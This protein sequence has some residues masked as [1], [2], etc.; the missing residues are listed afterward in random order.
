MRKFTLLEQKEFLFNSQ[1]VAI[2]TGDEFAK[3]EGITLTQQVTEY[4]TAVGGKALSP[5]YGEVILDKKGVDDDFAHG[6][7]RIK[8][9]A[10]AAV[11]QIIE[12]GTIILPMSQHKNDS[13]IESAMIGAPIEI[14]SKEYIGVVVIRRNK[15]G[16]T[17]LYIHEVTI[18]Q[19]LLEGSSNPAL[20]PATNQGVMSDPLLAVLIQPLCWPLI[21]E[22][23]Q[24]YCKKLYPQNLCEHLF[25]KIISNNIQR[26]IRYPTFFLIICQRGTNRR[27]G[28]KFFA[29][30]L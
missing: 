3:R 16:D 11:P 13:Q 10:F 4:Y 18:K 20:I 1:P 23:L 25:F 8:A 26:H 12:K 9:I 14:A 7:G 6:I 28:L 15:S 27:L 2:L 29:I 30:N 21:K 17:R 24:R 19:K 22:T 5:V